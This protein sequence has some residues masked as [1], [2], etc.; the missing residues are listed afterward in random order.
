MRA[1]TLVLLLLLVAWGAAAWGW[2][3]YELARKL[4]QPPPPLPYR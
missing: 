2:F 1:G 4:I 3:L